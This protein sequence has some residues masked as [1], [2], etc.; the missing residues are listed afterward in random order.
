MPVSGVRMSW[1]TARSRL[2]WIRSRSASRLRLS[3]CLARLVSMP[4][5][6]EMNIMTINV[7]GNPAS[8][9]LISQ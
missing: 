2:E 6:T 9:K 4:V 5:T 3:T 8:V 1:D 7:S